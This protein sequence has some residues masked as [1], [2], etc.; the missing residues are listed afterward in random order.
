[1][2]P[3]LSIS[4]LRLTTLAICREK[5]SNTMDNKDLANYRRMLR[6]DPNWSDGSMF[7]R[8]RLTIDCGTDAMQSRD[9]LVRALRIVADR[10]DR[11]ADSGKIMDINGN[12]CGRFDIDLNDEEG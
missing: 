10:I 6:S 11:G 1:M 3:A 4:P 8:L 9:D 2:I 5:E 12:T 7:L